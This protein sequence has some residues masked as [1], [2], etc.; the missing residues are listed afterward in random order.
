M[1]EFRYLGKLLFD[2]GR[3]SYRK[4]SELVL[5]NFYK[6][7]LL[8]LPQWW[9]GLLNGF[10]GIA[11]YDPWL[12][13]LYNTC[14]TAVPIILFATDD[15]EFS[16]K[17]LLANPRDY[18]RQGQ[19][20]R[21]FNYSNFLRNFAKGFFDA[22][23]VFLFSAYVFENNTV[24]DRNAHPHMFFLHATG[25]VSY[26]ASIIVSTLRVYIASYSLSII[27]SLTLA[28]SYLFYVL[29]YALYDRLFIN[30][31]SRGTFAIQFTSI[32]FYCVNLLVIV[33]TTLLDLASNV[34]QRSIESMNAAAQAKT[35]Q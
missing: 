29:S 23:I 2:F 3:E 27:Q 28:G 32:R 10:S 16:I 14:F 26:G 5:Y 15:R 6:N 24:N 35:L 21:L 30:P 1:P 31:D 33:C 13:Q 20:N 18:Y 4:N 11:L 25:M 34:F 17:A 19:L 8:V 22:F 9:F 12:Y 7:L